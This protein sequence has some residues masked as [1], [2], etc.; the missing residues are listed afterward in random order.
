MLKP[1]IK[2]EDWSG[3]LAISD[4]VYKKNQFQYGYNVDF[5][6]RP[7]YVAPAT[8]FTNVALSASV[9]VGGTVNAIKYAKKDGNTYVAISDRLYT[10][11]TG[12]IT[13]VRDSA[14]N[15][16]INWLEEYK[17]YLYYA[18]ATTIGRYDLSSTYTDSWQT[19]L[20]TTTYRPIQISGDNNMY[21]G[22]G[23]YLSKWDGTTWTANALDLQSGWEIQ[24]LANF[25]IQFI[26]I[27]ANYKPSSVQSG[28][29]IYLWDRLSSSWNDEIDIPENI[30]HS[31]ILANGML[32]VIAGEECNLYYVQIGSRTAQKIRLFRNLSLGRQTFYVYPNTMKY[33]NGR[34]YFALS[35]IS[36][37]SLSEQYGGIFSFNPEIANFNLNQYSQTTTG[38]STYA[39]GSVYDGTN[40]GIYYGTTSGSN[41]R[42]VVENSLATAFRYDSAV[43]QYTFFAPPGKKIYI[44]GFGADF[45]KL[46]SSNVSVKVEAQKDYSGSYTEIIN[47]STSNGSSVYQP[48]VFEGRV[49]QLQITL[50]GDSSSS[51]TTG[52]PFL[53]SVFA[54]GQLIDDTR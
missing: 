38:I 11:N 27:G 32:W 5:Y 22:N 49:I 18:Q 28:A 33:S 54:T 7:G 1:I 36:S 12:S 17:G 21:V 53:R 15:T 3:G 37:D 6:S 19:G 42:L 35:N 31:M 16:N 25:G 34:V 45:L 23:Q 40:G 20:A 39:I 2:I 30:I 41:Y 46:P 24:C 4:K 29:K 48:Y 51:S 47:Y 43:L 9:D 52:R 44:D 10:S 26:A 50:R 13:L 14:N 8:G